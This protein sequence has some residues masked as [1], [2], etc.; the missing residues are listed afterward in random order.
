MIRKTH[1]DYDVREQRELTK[2]ETRECFLCIMDEIHRVSELLGI[3]Y[4]LFFGTLLGAV[5]H[6]G[7]IPWDDDT[8]IVMFR[9]DY[10]VFVEKFNSVANKRYKL[11]HFSNTKHYLWSFAKVIDTYT[12]LVDPNYYIPFEYGLFCDIFPLNIVP[13]FKNEESK[14]HDY[15]EVMKCY[16]R[17]A[18]AN[19]WYAPKLNKFGALY[20]FILYKGKHR[21]RYFFKDPSTVNNEFDEYMWHAGDANPTSA[22]RASPVWPDEIRCTFE[23][24]LLDSFELASF[25]D[26]MYYI[27]SQYDAILKIL[28]GDYMTPPPEQYQN[29]YHFSSLKWR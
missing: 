13:F 26:R 24:K 17:Q 10:Q 9:N 28:Y 18:I 8:D 4:S 27:P 3:K 5:R 23:E 15:N 25:E 6:K 1:K 20:N 22:W 12:N 2:A 16:R 14:I 7:F 19:F 29:G 11:I 21:F